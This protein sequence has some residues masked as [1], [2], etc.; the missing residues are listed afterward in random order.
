MNFVPRFH[1]EDDDLELLWRFTAYMEKV[2]HNARIDYLR[3][4]DYL[5]KE[6]ALVQLLAD[7]LITYDDPISVNENEFDFEEERLAAAFPRLT[8]MRRRI[9]TLIYVDG[10]SPQEVADKL[11]CPIKLVYNHKHEALKRLRNLLMEGGDGH[12]E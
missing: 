6:G 7:N 12:G 2:V 4:Q 11:N 10:M 8:L 9:L 1:I 5:K 3:S